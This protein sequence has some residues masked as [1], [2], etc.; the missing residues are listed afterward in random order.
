MKIHQIITEARS[1][2]DEKFAAWRSLQDM[3]LSLTKAKSK[4]KI[5]GRA[6]ALLK[7]AQKFVKIAGPSFSF[8]REPTAGTLYSKIY[9]ILTKSHG[10]KE[11]PKP[12]STT[13]FANGIASYYGGKY[14]WRNPTKWMRS[15]GGSRVDPSDTVQFSNVQDRDAAW[16]DLKTRGKKVYIQDRH[17][18]HAPHMYLQFGSILVE[19]KTGTRPGAFGDKPEWVYELLF[20]T[21]S[22]LRNYLRIK[23]DITDQEAATLRDI[24][25]T[26]TKNTIEKLKN[27][28]QILREPERDPALQKIIDSTKIDPKTKDTLANIIAGAKD[29]K[30]PPT[31]I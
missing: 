22:I 11:F 27:I 28:L 26:K 6:P 24:A 2:Y 19:K 20:Q 25:D 12:I 4:A 10:V 23:H 7:D 14:V 9:D 8:S 3:H 1:T 18:D 15:S 13:A 30:E 16:E 29:F 5:A 21:T 31:D 17:M